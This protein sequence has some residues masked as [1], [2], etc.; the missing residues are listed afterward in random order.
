MKWKKT[1]SSYSNTVAIENTFKLMRGRMNRTLEIDE[2]TIL[3][4]TVPH[5]RPHFMCNLMRAS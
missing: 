4:V 3:Y 1:T 5:F 2:K